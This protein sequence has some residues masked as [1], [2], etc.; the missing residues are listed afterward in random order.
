M[1]DEGR[2]QQVFDCLLCRLV[3]VV[4]VDAVGQLRG[5]CGTRKVARRE[6]TVQLDWRVMRF[7]EL[8]EIIWASDAK[9]S[10]GLSLASWKRSAS[11]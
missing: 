10:V 6:K 9:R 2:K 8:L 4:P 3:H 7:F 1:R 5:G 11:A